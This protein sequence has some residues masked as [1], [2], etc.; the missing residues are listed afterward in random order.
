MKHLIGRLY[1]KAPIFFGIRCDSRKRAIAYNI[2]AGVVTAVV[3]V[4]VLVLR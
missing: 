1:Y 3:I 2:I 4:A